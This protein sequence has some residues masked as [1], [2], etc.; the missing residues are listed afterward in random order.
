MVLAALSN[1]VLW[2][3]QVVEAVVGVKKGRGGQVSYRLKWQD[4]GHNHNTWEPLCNIEVPHLLLGLPPT[5]VDLSLCH[6]HC[7]TLV[8]S[9][10][11]RAVGGAGLRSWRRGRSGCSRSRRWGSSGALMCR[12]QPWQLR[13]HRAKQRGG[14]KSIRS[15]GAVR[16]MSMCSTGSSRGKGSVG[17]GRQLRETVRGW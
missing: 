5:D 17:R 8:G 3:V 9:L 15:R 1:G 11:L 13:C 10:T 4:W 7:R 6:P 14:G 16:H 12:G 2:R